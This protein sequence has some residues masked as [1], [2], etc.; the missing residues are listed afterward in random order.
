MTRHW[1]WGLVLAAITLCAGRAVALDT[2]EEGAAAATYPGNAEEGTQLERQAVQQFQE[3]QYAEAARLF[4]RAWET[5]QHPRYQYN[6]G[7]CYRH[8]QRWDDAVAA[9]QRRLEIEPAP[10]N[11][12]YAHIGSCHLQA[13]RR[14]EANQAFRRYIELEPNGDMAPQVRQALEAGS[15]PEEERRS[16]EIV[17]QARQVHDRARQLSDAGE[18]EQ[19]AEAYLEGYRQFSQVHE[20]LLNAGLCYTWARRNEQAIEAFTQYLQTPGADP[21]AIAHLA[22][23]HMAEGDLPVARDT[24]QRYLQQDPDGELAQ[25]ARQVIRFISRL[26]P[27]PT[28]ANLEEAKE[29]ITRANE[30]AEA[31]RYRR[32]QRELEAAYE[33]I[34][35]PSVRYNIGACY[36]SR[37]EYEEALPYFLQYIQ[38]VGDEGVYASTHVDAAACLAE[39]NRNEEAM[40]HIR[41]YR[42]RADAAELPR[43]QYH[44]DRATAIENQCKED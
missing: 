9:Y 8:A 44:R 27:M 1:T 40:E 23:C 6:I 2:E 10:R 42:A 28:R 32:A 5:Y 31:G 12:I 17:Q 16:P 35:V 34:P 13:R 39:L 37:G 21:A 20:L 38:Q 25:Q 41:A 29:H 36:F 43:E 33:I 11:Y 18:F 30:H 15:W 24:Y 22:E 19:A 7:Q 3:H 14:Q 26:N 4:E